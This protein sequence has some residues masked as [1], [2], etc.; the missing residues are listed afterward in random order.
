MITG[1]SHKQWSH[2]NFF[3]DC[4]FLKGDIVTL[5]FILFL[6]GIFILNIRLLIVI[7]SHNKCHQL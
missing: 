7:Q 1:M 5:F 2:V 4:I 6:D 3:K